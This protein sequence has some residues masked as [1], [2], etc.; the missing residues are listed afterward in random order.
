M[1]VSTTMTIAI[2]NRCW[3][4][5]WRIVDEGDPAENAVVDR[6]E[7]L[8]FRSFLPL[9]PTKRMSNVK[10]GLCNNTYGLDGS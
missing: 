4:Q 6:V 9:N 8:L 2:Q 1:R 7:V 5:T 3:P 10:Q